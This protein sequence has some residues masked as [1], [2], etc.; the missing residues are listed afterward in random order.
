MRARRV[1]VIADL[2]PRGRAT[3]DL[4]ALLREAIPRATTC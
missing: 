2:H 1:E 3:L 4:V